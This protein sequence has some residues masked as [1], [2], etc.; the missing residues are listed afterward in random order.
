MKML[1]FAMAILFRAS[2]ASAVTEIRWARGA[3]TTVCAVDAKG[4]GE[5]AV[6]VSKDSNADLTD[7]LR[8]NA[9]L[10]QPAQ[11][12]EIRQGT[13]AVCAFNAYR[14]TQCETLDLR[15]VSGS[16]LRPTTKN[17]LA[18]V[19]LAFPAGIAKQARIALGHAFSADYQAKVVALKTLLAEPVN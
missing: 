16:Y 7:V 17:G 13:Y 9:G 11:W 12:L 3:D 8:I 19:K 5:C 18:A 4:R 6:A 1:I 2:A 10:R 14:Q 15:R